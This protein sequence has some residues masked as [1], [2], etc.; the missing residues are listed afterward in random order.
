MTLKRAKIQLHLKEI[1]TYVKLFSALEDAWKCYWE[2]Q[3]L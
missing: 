2:G 1:L 3:V